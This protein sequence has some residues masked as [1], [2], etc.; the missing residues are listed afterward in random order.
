MFFT[1]ASRWV[2]T[3]KWKPSHLHHVVGA[4]VLL[5]LTLLLWTEFTSR[6]NLGPM[7]TTFKNQLQRGQFLWLLGALLLMPLNWLAETL[8][9]QPFLYQ[10]TPLSLRQGLLAVWVGVS[11]SLF[12]PNRMGE[13]GGRILLVPPEHRLK[14][15]W[16]NLTGNF[17][18]ILIILT[19]GGLGGV[20]MGFRQGLWAFETLPFLYVL[21][22]VALTPLYVL[23]FSFQKYL[24]WLQ[25][26]SR[27][28]WWQRWLSEGRVLEQI[29]TRAASA[30]LG[31]A[32]LRY[33]TYCTQYFFLLKFF[34]VAPGFL[35]AYSGITVLFLIQTCLPLTPLLALFLRGNLAAWVW[36]P[37][38]QN[39]LSC[40]ASSYVL[41]IINLILP[42]LIGTFSLFHVNIAKQRA[43]EDD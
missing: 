30:L 28:R 19:L 7:V 2:Q 16:I 40:M 22:A 25:R 29:S 23:Y 35:L 24:P 8:K 3:L 36:L 17:S 37:F 5:L 34:A 12:T 32:L 1:T 42:A 38:G 27:W 15:V 26:L 41:W 11:F 4:V 18:Q 21:A 39:A 14:A 6:E 10:Y 20:Y 31:W 33:L 13:Y 43:Y 9:W